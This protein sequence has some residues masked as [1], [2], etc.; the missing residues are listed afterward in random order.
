MKKLFIGGLPFATRD[1]ELRELFS[2][3]GTPASATVIFDRATG[4][5]KGFGFVEF[6]NDEE[7]NRAIE[8][9]D[10]TDLGGRKI[11]VNEARPMEDRPRRESRPYG[12]NRG[13]Y[14]R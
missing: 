10:G 4:R 5:S 1:E 6:E 7:A 14:N 2:K 9:F 3:A 13:G 11:I 12:E 8:M